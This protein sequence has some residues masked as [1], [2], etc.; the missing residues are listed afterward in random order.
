[1]DSYMDS[2]CYEAVAYDH[3][4]Q[5]TPTSMAS[6]VWSLGVPCGMYEA[7]D[8]RRTGTC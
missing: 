8:Q 4:M 7:G 3:E 5:P 1:M 2:Y 6:S